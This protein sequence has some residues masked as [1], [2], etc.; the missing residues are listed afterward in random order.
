MQACELAHPGCEPPSEG[1]V[2]PDDDPRRK[3]CASL[4]LKFGIQVW[5]HHVLDL[6]WELNEQDV[7]LSGGALSAP[8]RPVTGGLFCCAILLHHLLG[9]VDKPLSKSHCQKGVVKS[10]GHKTVVKKQLPGAHAS[11]S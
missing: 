4:Q 9:S 6:L 11:S 2:R 8:S 10:H 1:H 5:A 7:C 3:Q